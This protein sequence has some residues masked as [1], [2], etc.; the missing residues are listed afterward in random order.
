MRDV[1]PRRVL[2]L[3]SHQTFI[4]HL[5][6]PAVRILGHPTSP[7]YIPIFPSSHLPTSSEEKREVCQSVVSTKMVES[8]AKHLDVNGVLGT[9]L[10]IWKIHENTVVF[11]FGWS[12]VQCW[13]N[14]L[15]Y[16]GQAINH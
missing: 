9:V 2:R 11:G 13:K 3:S 4:H 6:V 7:P 12:Y 8:V 15:G 10:M 5:W 14:G 16:I 1:L